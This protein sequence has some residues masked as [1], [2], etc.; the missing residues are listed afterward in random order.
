MCSGTLTRFI[1]LQGNTVSQ[2]NI[3]SFLVIISTKQSTSL[4]TYLA[5]ACFVVSIFVPVHGDS[6]YFKSLVFLTLEC[7]FKRSPLREW[8]QFHLIFRL[9]FWTANK[10]NFMQIT[11]YSWLIFSPS[12]SV[13][14]LREML[15]P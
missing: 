14:I 2:Q 12:I 1:Q 4:R 13:L 7:K 6:N 5:L 8:L 3:R 11:T 15:S 10:T 9:H